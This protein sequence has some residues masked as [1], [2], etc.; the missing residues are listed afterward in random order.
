[1]RVLWVLMW[2]LASAAYAPTPV[3]GQARSVR[4]S[5]AGWSEEEPQE[6][7]R[8]WRDRDGDVLTLV[9]LDSPFAGLDFST[10]VELQNSAR[11]L[12]QQLGGGLIEVGVVALRPHSIVSLIYKRLQLPA[13]VYTGM[14]IMERQDSSLVW[15]VVAVEHG[16]T[17]VR[18]AVVTAEMMEA[19]DLTIDDYQ[20]SWA[21]DPYDPTYDGVDRSVLRFLSDDK[22]YDMRF[23]QHPLSKVRRVL[24][25][26]PGT[27]AG[28]P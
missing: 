10:E 13:Y 6:G 18:E 1:M 4:L 26:L 22:R 3:S 9:V 8:V 14:L 2:L 20:R 17:G 27:V 12:A 7:T 23:P 21:Q 19:G 16:T 28:V 11:Q 5:L 15:T 25:A 24:T